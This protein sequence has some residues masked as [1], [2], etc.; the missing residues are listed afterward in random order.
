MKSGNKIPPLPEKVLIISF[1][2]LAACGTTPVS[3]SSSHSNIGGDS[4]NRIDQRSDTDNPGDTVLGDESVGDGIGTGGDQGGGDTS[5]GDSRAAQCSACHGSLDSAAPPRSLSGSI[6]TSEKGVG[7]H[8]AHLGSGTMFRQVLCQDCH[9]VPENVDAETHI[10]NLLPAEITFSTLATHNGSI[11]ASWNGSSCTVYCHGSASIGALNPTPNW[12]ASSQAYC[13]SCHSLPPPASAGHVQYTQCNDCHPTLDENL[14]FVSPEL[15]VNGVVDIIRDRPCGFC[16]DVPPKTGAHT[17]HV[18]NG[19]LVP[20]YGGLATSADLFSTPQGAYTFGCGQCHPTNLDKHMDGTLQVEL[21]DKDAPAQS[22]KALNASNAAFDGTS[23]S[24]VYCHEPVMAGLNTTPDWQ[25]GTLGPNP[26]TECHTTL[27]GGHTR[28]ADAEGVT[29]YTFNRG[30]ACTT[31]HADVVNASNT[32]VDTRLH[33]SGAID[34]RFNSTDPRLNGTETY[35]LKSGSFAPSNGANNAYGSCN[36]VYC[37]SAVQD[38][39]GAGEA[40]PVTQFTEVTWGDEQF[41]AGCH[42]P[43][44]N[45]GLAH[46]RLLNTGSHQVHIQNLYDKG[47]IACTICHN[48][49]QV[50]GIQQG[51]KNFMCHASDSDREQ[52]FH[53]NGEVNVMLAPELST[54]S[55][56]YTGSKTPGDNFGSCVD[57]YCHSPGDW[58]RTGN[59]SANTSAVWGTKGPLACNSCH[60]NTIYTGMLA[61]M[62]AYPNGSPKENTHIT[63]AVEESIPCKRCHSTLSDAGEGFDIPNLH[64]DTRFDVLP[65]GSFNGSA[66]YFRYIQPTTQQAGRC[67]QVSCHP[68]AGASAWWG[69]KF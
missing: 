65:S 8:Q 28:H 41:C 13:G 4:G 26:C 50:G 24:N 69:G 34:W 63:H 46:G 14:S 42:V 31:C 22:I 43:S 7:A 38:E 56:T 37:H 16:H 44:G 58:R 62:P 35:S 18:A 55:T 15:H 40:A 64:T 5:S 52:F 32:I 36:N 10:D 1:S 59:I 61:A 3:S 47:P 27:A 67:S 30:F 49:K 12:T 25:G 17:A 19:A 54:T 68:S 29:G 2:L 45:G 11:A 33:V 39:L 20:V 48:W 23:C 51:C 9:V 6:E 53:A 66:V 57:S 21:F 60:G